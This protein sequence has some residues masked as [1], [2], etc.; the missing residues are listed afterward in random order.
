MMRQYAATA[1]TAICLLTGAV[2]AA[3]IAQQQDAALLQ[4]LNLFQNESS[5]DT[6]DDPMTRA[7]AAVML[8]RL[9]GAE[10][11]MPAQTYSI[12]FTDVADWARPYVSWLYQRGWTSGTSSNTFSPD[13]PVTG[14]QYALFLGRALGYSDNETASGQAFALSDRTLDR[15][16][17]ITRGQAA[18]MTVDALFSVRAD[19]RLLSDVLVESGVVEAKAI[20]QAANTRPTFAEVDR[21]ALQNSVWEPLASTDGKVSVVRRQN[22]RKKAQSISFDHVTVETGADGIFG[23]TADAIYYLD[24]TTLQETRIADLP[25]ITHNQT[26]LP[27]LVGVLSSLDGTTLFYIRTAITQDSQ[28]VYT[29]RSWSP[30]RG[31]TDICTYT[32]YLTGADVLSTVEG[33]Y[34][35]G[36]FGI[37]A[38]TQSGT[39][40]ILTRTPCYAL[41]LLD[42]ILYFIPEQSVIQA[43]GTSSGGHEV[44]MLA[45]GQESTVLTLPTAN[46]YPVCIQTVTAASADGQ[47]T[48]R[49]TW[50]DQQ[51]NAWYLTFSGKGTDVRVI[52]ANN[53]YPVPNDLTNLYSASEQIK[54]WNAALGLTVHQ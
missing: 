53:Q 19:G 14:T 50:K 8:V 20:A 12:P 22:N 52:D 6:L 32:G 35:S 18:S 41:T 15:S 31:W 28:A 1:L 43:N 29:L 42:G 11:S 3:S 54:W 33:K 16:Q 46:L 45:M 7:Q 48:A 44:R 25:T 49:G 34:V 24:P 40:E 39:V 13:Q 27:S 2:S 36:A 4:S 10:S 47:I 5:G 51:D 37:L 23:Y 9:F 26:I 17:T 21:A 30:A 38:L